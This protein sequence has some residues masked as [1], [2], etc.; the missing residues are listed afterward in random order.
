MYR[1]HSQNDNIP[2]FKEREKQ[3]LWIN[4]LD[5]S[6]RGI[7]DQEEVNV[8]SPQGLMRIV[9]YVTEDI[10]PGA[11]CLLQGVWPKFDS[12]G[13]ET[14]GS[15]NILTSTVP[16]MPSFGSRTHSVFV[17]VKKTVK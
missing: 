8:S 7:E 9:S 12:S 5:A 6:Q 16:T 1:V 4:P 3:A 10:M 15:A 17:Q 14:A 2:W 11:V 13:A